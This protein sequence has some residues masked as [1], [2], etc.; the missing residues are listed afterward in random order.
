MA[1]FTSPIYAQSFGS[2]SE[3]V[4]IPVISKLNPTTQDIN[5]PIGKRWINTLSDVVFAL[6]SFNINPDLVTRLDANWI[7]LSSNNFNISASGLSGALISG[8]V[9][10]VNSACRSNSTILITASQVAGQ[11]GNWFVD[12]AGIEDGHF[13]IHSNN[14]NDNTDF[15]YAIVN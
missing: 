5:Y 10:V 8:A 1:A 15:M 6:S 14:L 7:S 11:I 9:T 3:N 12:P 13:I 2:H 4:E